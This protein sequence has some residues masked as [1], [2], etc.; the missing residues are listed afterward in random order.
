MTASTLVERVTEVLAG[1][2]YC[3]VGTPREIAGLPAAFCGASPSPDLHSCL[4]PTL[5]SRTNVRSLRSL[6]KTIFEYLRHNLIYKLGFTDSLNPKNIKLNQSYNRA[7]TALRTHQEV[8]QGGF[9]GGRPGGG[10]MMLE[11]PRNTEIPTGRNP[12]DAER[13]IRLLCCNNVGVHRWTRG[14]GW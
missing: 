3:R 8:L 10:C 7:F 2:G 13:R 14:S 1:A 9:A 5:P 4:L 12:V 11:L 6:S